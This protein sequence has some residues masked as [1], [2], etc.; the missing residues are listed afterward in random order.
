MDSTALV[1]LAHDILA[2]NHTPQKNKP[3]YYVLVAQQHV[4]V[5]EMQGTLAARLLQ[6]WH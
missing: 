3:T 1:A 4:A 5:I 6:P 2:C